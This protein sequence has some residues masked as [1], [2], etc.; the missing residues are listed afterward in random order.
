MLCECNYSSRSGFICRGNVTPDW[1]HHDGF[2]S[3]RKSEGV[4][5]LQ[6]AVGKVGRL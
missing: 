1:C 3:Q 4:D 6:Q 5:A 2:L